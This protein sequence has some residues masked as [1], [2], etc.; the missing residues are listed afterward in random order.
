ME[1]LQ[2]LSFC[3]QSF[4]IFQALIN[5]SATD[6]RLCGK[7][8]EIF[9]SIFSKYIESCLNQKIFTNFGDNR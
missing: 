1:E 4:S 5:S 3:Q 2:N 8:N 7:Y 9:K 6:W